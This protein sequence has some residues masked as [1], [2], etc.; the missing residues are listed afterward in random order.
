MSQFIDAEGKEVWGLKC[1]N[2]AECKPLNQ[3]TGCN[4]KMRIYNR[5]VNAALNMLK[6]VKVLIKTGKRIEIYKK[7]W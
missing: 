1:C 2:S 5:D 4:Y 7:P 6:I 3:R